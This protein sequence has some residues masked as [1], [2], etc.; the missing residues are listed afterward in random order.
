M[1][2]FTHNCT[3]QHV[4]KDTR[5]AWIRIG[6]GELCL[7]SRSSCCRVSPPS[8]GWGYLPFGTCV[9]QAGEHSSVPLRKPAVC[10]Q[11]LLRQSGV[12]CSGPGVWD[13][14]SHCAERDQLRPELSTP[15]HLAGAWTPTR[16]HVCYRTCSPVP[17]LIPNPLFP[18]SISSCDAFLNVFQSKGLRQE[19]ICPCAS[20]PEALTV[21]IRR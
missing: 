15:P 18:G 3:E 16:G 21:A 12:R 8:Q 11:A 17:C 19:V 1:S 13:T 6:P 5:S 4:L 7:S 10:R 14:A 20:S 9:L 2:C